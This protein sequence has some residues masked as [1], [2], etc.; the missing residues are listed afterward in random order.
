MIT[1]S[2][3]FVR[4]ALTI[5]KKKTK[6]RSL[7]SRCHTT[8]DGGPKLSLPETL[9]GAPWR[10]EGSQKPCRYFLPMWAWRLPLP[11]EAAEA[12]VGSG[13]GRWCSP[14]NRFWTLLCSGQAV[15]F[16][17]SDRIGTLS[18]RHRRFGERPLAPECGLQGWSGDVFQYLVRSRA[19]LGSM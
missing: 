14:P 19:S 16:S 11:S 18:P 4:H 15:R 9:G 12:C 1:I 8:A 3:G 6:Y 17:E 5:R 7:Q 10:V 13:D 2:E